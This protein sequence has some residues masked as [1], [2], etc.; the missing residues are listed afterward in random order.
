MALPIARTP[1]LDSEEF[2]T[3]LKTME[4]NKTKPRDIEKEK[5]RKDLYLRITKKAKINRT[6]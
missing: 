4:I 2:L 1:E 6:I 5:E 3:L